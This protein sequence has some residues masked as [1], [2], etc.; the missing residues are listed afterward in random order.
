MSHCHYVYVYIVHTQHILYVNIFYLCLCVTLVMS[1]V[2]VFLLHHSIPEI[3]PRI[4]YYYY[5]HNPPC[6]HHM[7]PIT[8]CPITHVSNDHNPPC[9]HH[10]YPIT[11]CP[12]T[13]VSNDHNSPCVQ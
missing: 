4:L 8:M 3:I 7:Y 5:D 6:V 2:C 12:I 10:M 11:M 13:H 9:V 1:Q